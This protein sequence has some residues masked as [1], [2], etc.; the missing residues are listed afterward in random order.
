MP[1]QQR[2]LLCKVCKASDEPIAELAGALVQFAG[3]Y[4]CLEQRLL[5]DLV[6]MHNC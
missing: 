4:P 6:G 3:M 5:K 1:A 2:Q